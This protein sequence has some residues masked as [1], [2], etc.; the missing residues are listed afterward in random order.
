MEMFRSAYCHRGFS[1][2]ELMIAL[3]L[4]L[5]IIL[6]V[7]DLFV[8]S[9]RTQGD[10]SRTSRQLENSLF[11]LDLLAGELALVGYW[12]EADYPLVADD[13]NFGPLRF[14]EMAGEAVSGYPSPPLL[15]VGSGNE[16][17]N[18]RVEL[19]W[20]MEYPLVSGIGFDLEVAMSSP[21]CDATISPPKDTEEF[22]AIRRASTCA[23]NDSSGADCAPIGNFFHLQVNGCYDLN[24]GLS[25][26]ETK[27]RRVTDADA[28]S[29]LDYRNLSCGSA[30]SDRAPIY[31][32]VSRIYYVNHRDELVR[33][34][35]AE[36][37]TYVETVLV[38]GVEALR[39]E[40]LIDRSS[41]GD[42]DVVRSVADESWSDAE[43]AIDWQNIVGVNMTM[44][45][46][47]SMPQPGF[48]DA[49]LYQLPGQTWV[50]D[51]T[52]YPRIRRSRT[53]ELINVAGRRR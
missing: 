51:K 49:N 45:V 20:A 22:V 43:R 6:G 21:A 36:S 25:G 53:V 33:L 46:R 39:F 23:A 26:G 30:L 42:Y 27:L 15:C 4:G 5:V 13:P 8:D 47:S 35:L 14:T 24:A 11:A 19:G 34:E 1:L 12:G 17:R 50:N 48:Q 18:P 32:Y 37:N 31:R 40:W 10:V 7:T 41:D 3:L 16:G 38:E 28:G 29:V 44:I 9:S 52:Q 2:I